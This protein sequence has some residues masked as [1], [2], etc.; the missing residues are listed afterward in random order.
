MS[1]P[2][3]V[4]FIDANILPSTVFKDLDGPTFDKIG[5]N[6]T[7]PD[8]LEHDNES[9]LVETILKSSRDV[10]K[11]LPVLLSLGAS[12]VLKKVTSELAKGKFAFIM[13][14]MLEIQ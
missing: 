1:K 13:Y 2:I 14:K 5:F 6:Y 12:T 9:E 11:F 10:Y 7:G 3:G 4:V 8:S